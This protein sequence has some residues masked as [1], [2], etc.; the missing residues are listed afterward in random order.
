VGIP[1]FNGENFISD[2]ISSVLE[3][4]FNDFELIIIDNYSEDNTCAIVNSFSDS[5]I[6]LIINDRNIGSIANFNKC[7]EVANGEYFILLPHDDALLPDAL[8]TLSDLIQT[9][10]N[11]GLAYSSYF[12]IDEQGKKLNKKNFPYQTGILNSH[13]AIKKFII[14]RNPVQLALVRTKVLHNLGGFDP[15]KVVCCDIDLWSRIA[16]AGYRI[17]FEKTPLFCTRVHP[18]Q[19]QLLFNDIA[20]NKKYIL[21][22]L[23]NSDNKNFLRENL[24]SNT[25]LEYILELFKRIDKNSDLQKLRSLAIGWPIGSQIPNIY[26]SMKNNNWTI[27]YLEIEV[28]RKIVKW[29]GFKATFLA[30]FKYFLSKIKVIHN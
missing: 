8:K 4:T 19:G 23:V 17:A 16:L 13:D 28:L 9:D 10:S 25:I 2:S 15:K 27:F 30:Y 21:N 6:K 14:Y 12:T 5:R 29:V 18:A 24:L 26:N 20:K 7:I 3:Q 1:V 11:V 22:H